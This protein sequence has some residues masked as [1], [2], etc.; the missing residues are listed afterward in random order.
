MVKMFSTNEE[1]VC[2]LFN[3]DGEFTKDGKK[4]VVDIAGK[5]GCYKGEPKTDVYV[6]GIEK[7][8]GE[9]LELKISYKQSNADFIE[10]KMSAERAK[11]I[12]GNDWVNIIVDSTTQLEDVFRSLPL[13]FCEKRGRTQRGSFTLGWKFELLRVKSGVLSERLLLTESEMLDVYSGTNLDHDKRDAFVQGEQIPNSGVCNYAYEEL[14]HVDSAQEVVDRLIPIEKY[15]LQNPKMYF[16][17]KALNY[18]SFEDKFDGNRPL[19]VY[20]DWY[21]S[22]GLLC[23]NIIF[24]KPLMVGGNEACDNLRS[25]LNELGISNTA[26]LRDSM[27]ADKGIIYRG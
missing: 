10:N 5:P 6:R 17:C 19:S 9:T 21:I 13:I 26:E 24:D 20:V 27:V 11:Q 7:R 2:M 1:R 16:A 25:C 23:H 12:L 8:T 4:Y 3:R 14:F 18:R 22:N 15:V